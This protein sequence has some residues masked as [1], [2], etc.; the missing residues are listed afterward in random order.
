MVPY[1]FTSVVSISIAWNGSFNA[2]FIIHFGICYLVPETWNICLH[3]KSCSYHYN[4]FSRFHNGTRVL[5]SKNQSHRRISR[6]RRSSSLWPNRRS[7]SQYQ[8]LRTANIIS[9]RFQLDSWFGILNE[10]VDLSE[11]LVHF[12]AFHFVSEIRKHWWILRKWI[13]I[14]Y[15]NRKVTSAWQSI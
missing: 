14:R 2:E 8:P 7:A 10:C 4:T 5:R 15:Q 3:M 1:N 13:L 12:I 9:C 11:N 6:S